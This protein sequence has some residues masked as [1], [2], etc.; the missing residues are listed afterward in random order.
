MTG[1]PGFHGAA[2]NRL[3]EFVVPSGG[4]RTRKAIEKVAPMLS[5]SEREELV[6]TK[7][8][9]MAEPGYGRGAWLNDEDHGQPGEP[10]AALTCC[11]GSR[12]SPRRRFF[13]LGRHDPTS[14]HAEELKSLVPRL[15][16]LY[17]RDGR[18]PDSLREPG[19]VCAAG[20]GLPGIATIIERKAGRAAQAA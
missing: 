10:P 3:S 11:A 17:H 20:A 18:P 15:A 14:E 16:R 1:N 19:R 13:L 2:N 4:R 12:T 8:R 9:K 5:E 6:Q 7:V